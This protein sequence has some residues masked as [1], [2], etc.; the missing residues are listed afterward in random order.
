MVYLKKENPLEV[1]LNGE[2]IKIT[3]EDVEIL[4]E[5]I[6]GLIVESENGVTVAIDTD[7][8]PELISEGM[9]REFVNRVQ[10]MRKDAGFDVTDK[11]KIA[12]SGNSDLSFAI[13]SFANYISVETLAVKIENI[14]DPG[15]GFTQDQKIGDK[16]IKIKI[17]KVS[18]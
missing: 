3:L 13:N 17:E 10:N 5:Q 16:E 9:A 18:I 6:S 1:D 8:S 12:F 2:N 11:I 15:G 14:A 4:S 7:L